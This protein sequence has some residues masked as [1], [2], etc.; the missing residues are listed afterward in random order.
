MSPSD[1][2]EGLV[3][4]YGAALSA[5]VR[6][7]GEA[8]LVRAYELGRKAAAEGLGILDLA[9]LHHQAVLRLPTAPDDRP[10]LGMATQFLV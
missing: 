3:Q 6:G 8:A 1:A 7:A 4:E 2:T 5:Y 9:M 10:P